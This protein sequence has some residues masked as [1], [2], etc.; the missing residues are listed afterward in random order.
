MRKVVIAR[1]LPGSGKSTMIKLL[2]GEAHAEGLKKHQTRVLSNDDY[3]MRD[4][5]YCYDPMKMGH[6]IKA[7]Q[8]AFRRAIGAH[9]PWVAVD[10]THVTR[11]EYRDY[12]VWAEAAGYTVQFVELFDGG[13]SD[14]ELAARNTHGVPV[15]KIS[16]RRA[17]WE[18]L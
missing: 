16:A 12:I 13:L 4:G 14:M 18:P 1:G 8:D 3:F 17:Q 7:C 2:R 10:N 9:V 6:A 5:Q 15:E 11:M